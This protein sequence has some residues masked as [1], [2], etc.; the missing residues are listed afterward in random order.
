MRSPLQNV[1]FK[2]IDF[3][4]MVID[5]NKT[6]WDTDAWDWALDYHK[7]VLRSQPLVMR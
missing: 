7:E 6:L 5:A 1:T 3:S 4:P 2:G